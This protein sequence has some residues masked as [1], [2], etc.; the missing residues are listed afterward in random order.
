MFSVWEFITLIWL[1]LWSAFYYIAFYPQWEVGPFI[2]LW[3]WGLILSYP[4]VALFVIVCDVL[5]FFPGGIGLIP[6]AIGA[7]FDVPYGKE[8]F[9]AT[10]FLHVIYYYSGFRITKYLINWS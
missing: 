4:L 8:I 1:L 7:Y 6:L 10:S 5:N 3:F 9:L 2:I